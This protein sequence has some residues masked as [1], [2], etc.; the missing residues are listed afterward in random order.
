MAENQ[1]FLSPGGGIVTGTSH[2]YVRGTVFRVSQRVRI[3]GVFLQSNIKGNTAL[4][5]I[6]RASDRTIL[7]S[8]DVIPQSTITMVPISVVLEPNTDYVISAYAPELR[9][10]ESPTTS[11]FTKTGP[12]GTV[13]NGT[14][15]VVG[16]SSGDIYPDATAFGSGFLAFYLNYKLNSNPTISVT[17]N[18]QVVSAVAGR[19]T[20]TLS[21]TV[22][23]ED[24]DTVTISATINGKTKT[25]SVANTSTS[26]A[27][28]LTWDVVND[29]IAQG[30]YTNIV[31]TA[32]DGYGGVNTATYTGTVTVDRTNPVITITGVTNGATYQNPVTP[33]FSATDSGGSGLASITATLNG[34]SYTSGTP[35]TTSGTKTL[36]VTATDNAGNQVQQTVNFTINKAPTVTLTTAD[37]QTLS[38]GTALS[39]QGSASEVDN[40]NVITVKYKI[41]NGTERALHSTVSDGSSPISFAKNLTFQGDRLYDG[42][43]DVSGPLA[44]GTTHTLSVWAIDDQGGTSAVVTRSFMVRYNKGPTIT[45]DPYTATQTGLIEPDTVTL[46]GSASDPDGNTFTVKGKLNSGA[47][48]TLL[49]GVSSGNWTFSFP[50]SSLQAGSNTVTITATDQ[51]GKA[52]IK[53]FSVN[54]TEQ[55]TPLTKG[56]A[57]YDVIPPLGTAKEILAWLKRQKGDLIVDVAASFVDAGQPEQYIAATKSSVDL[58][59][60]IAEDEFVVSVATAKPDIVFKQT[61][62]RADANST[63]AATSLVG[64]IE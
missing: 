46:S 51:F 32:D 40:G 25:K 5:K 10:D 60:E 15:V 6:W 52:T 35:I 26:K 43:T 19:K 1:I 2:N 34:A 27:W 30:T 55:K 64:V 61:F 37:N 11:A 38:E 28:S 20:I 14:K 45:V 4:I 44:E 18:N 54:K 36:V 48:Q 56:V 12:D 41:N 62:T 33:T 16:S 63:Q 13:F 7:A 42:T 49:N 9:Y 58:T 47:E 57:R 50:V 3:T 59:T 21:G 31:V 23:D 53:T 24:N 22:S 29:N 8:A 17:N 39:I